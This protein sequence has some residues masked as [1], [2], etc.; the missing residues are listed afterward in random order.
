MTYFSEEIARL[1]ANVSLEKITIF[2]YTIH[3]EWVPAVNLDTLV[4]SS[5]LSQ[6]EVLFETKL[7]M[8]LKKKIMSVLGKKLVF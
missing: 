1:R 5:M 6:I 2:F 8:I 3:K 4:L 7:V